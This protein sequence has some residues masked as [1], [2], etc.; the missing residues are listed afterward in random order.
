MLQ[1]TRN[2]LKS[3]A[4]PAFGLKGT[5]LLKEG[6]KSRSGG[7]GVPILNSFDKSKKGR[8]GGSKHFPREKQRNQ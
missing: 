5:K 4:G 6:G 3:D 1:M 7:G 2:V 8:E